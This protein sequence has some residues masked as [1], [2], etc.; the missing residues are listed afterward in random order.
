MNSNLFLRILLAVIAC[1][2][3][4][5]LLGPVFRLVGFPLT[6]DLLLVFEICIA[7]IALFYIIR[8]QPQ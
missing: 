7:G 1:V 6:S 4:F 2:L 5:A 3:L 8:G